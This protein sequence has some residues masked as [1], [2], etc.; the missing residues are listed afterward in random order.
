MTLR[1]EPYLHLDDDRVHAG[2]ERLAGRGDPATLA[3]AWLY[4]HP[5]VT[6]VVAGPRRVEHLE[7]A[8]A[9]LE[10]ELDRD[11]LTELFQAAPTAARRSPTRAATRRR[12]PRSP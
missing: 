5:Q 9:A 2:L 7:P 11:E 1:P 3:F 4:L 6:A 8:L 10:L 12:P